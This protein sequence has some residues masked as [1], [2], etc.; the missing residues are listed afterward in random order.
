MTNPL[1]TAAIPTAVAALNALS[2]FI[3]NLGSDPAQVAAKFPGALQVL[4]GTL[5]MQVPGLAAN[6]IAALQSAANQKIAGWISTLNKAQS[7]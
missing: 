4:L 5:E 6:E 2:Q 7:S 3:T 1:E